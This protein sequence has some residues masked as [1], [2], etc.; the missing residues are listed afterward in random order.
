LDTCALL[1]WTLDP[2]KLSPAAA[3][4]CEA[5]A[6][7]GAVVSSISVWE[8]G[9]KVKKGKLALP[10]PFPEYVGR[11]KK[12][13]GLEIVP[14]SDTIWLENLSLDWDNSD[15]ADRTIVATAR[16]R[17]LP[18]VTKDSRMAAYYDKVVW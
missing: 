8:I 15:P 7:E 18:I 14:V 13:D 6:R 17:N 1:W 11:L 10:I 12:V 16:L 9:I 2:K 4:A 3:T 5:A